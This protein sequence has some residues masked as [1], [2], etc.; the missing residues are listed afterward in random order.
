VPAQ[1]SQ[2]AAV[3][4][5]R[6]LLI[7]DNA[8][9]REAM[10]ALLELDGHHVQAAADGPQGLELARTEPPEIVLIDIGLPGMDGFEVA[11]RMRALGDPVV[12]VALTGYGQPEDRRRTQEAGFDA[13]LVKPVDPTDLTH[14]LASF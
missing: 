1:Q 5:R 13:H 10:C 14:A 7:E 3:R 6:I 12:L 11:R 2:P 9:A 4:P 8:D